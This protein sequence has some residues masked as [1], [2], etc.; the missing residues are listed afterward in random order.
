MPSIS[1]PLAQMPPPL[2]E[3]PAIP[4]AA[5][6]KLEKMPN[7]AQCL[8]EISRAKGL[9]LSQRSMEERKASASP[10]KSQ[11]KAAAA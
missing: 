7:M 1:L 6:A 10:P 8:D 4:D 3:V 5:L 9:R 11:K 2:G